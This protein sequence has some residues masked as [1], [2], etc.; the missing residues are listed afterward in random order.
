MNELELLIRKDL[1]S[2]GINSPISDLIDVFET[3]HWSHLPII[4]DGVFHG[5]F[6][7]EDALTLDENDVLDQHR[8]LW[9]GFFARPQLHW[10]EC[11]EIALKN[12]SNILPM[13]DQTT[14][15]LGVI[16]LEELL[17]IFQQTP[18]VK[19]KGAMIV[20]EKDLVDY[21][22][23]QVVQ[24]VESGNGRILGLFASDIQQNRIQ[25]TIKIVSGSIQNILQTFRR[26]NYEIISQ[27][28]DD[29]YVA[30]LKERS[31]YLDKYLNI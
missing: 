21:S 5:S 15:Y 20:V 12:E 1:P 19:E 6:S 17:G 30:N 27:H 9:Q 3:E 28:E 7:R 22:M 10:L 24:I 31:A 13:L 14:N 29:S 2:F 25:V 26:Y 8:Y 4:E 18:F 23:G 16:L 11:W